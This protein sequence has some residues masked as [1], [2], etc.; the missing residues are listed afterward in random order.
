M[1]VSL[2][3][4]PYIQ[5]AVVIYMYTTQSQD[6]QTHIH[7]CDKLLGQCAAIRSN[8]PTHPPEVVVAGSVGHAQFAS[9]LTELLHRHGS[10]GRATPLDKLLRDLLQLCRKQETPQTQAQNIT[11]ASTCS[12]LKFDSSPLNQEKMRS[13]KSI[14]G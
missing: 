9:H 14:H 11:T 2:L 6:T 8:S 7:T 5:L 1:T 3:A 4:L 10:T 13:S 12:K